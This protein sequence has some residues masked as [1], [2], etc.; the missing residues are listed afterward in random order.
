MIR[1]SVGQGTEPGFTKAGESTDQFWN[2]DLDDLLSILG[3]NSCGKTHPDCDVIT[4]DESEQRSPRASKYDIGDA[5]SFFESPQSF[6]TSSCQN[7]IHAVYVGKM[8]STPN[9][10]LRAHSQSNNCL[11]LLE[12]QLL[13]TNQAVSVGARA[14]PMINDVVNNNI[15][16]IRS[17]SAHTTSYKTKNSSPA[18]RKLMGSTQCSSRLFGILSLILQA[19][20]SPMTAELEQSCVSVMQRALEEIQNAH[21]YFQK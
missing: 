3:L 18:K 1:R 6:Q 10:G 5:T 14:V 9:S 13:E 15:Q 20:D 16:P 4:I 2:Q 11:V 19:F 12:N 8:H 17:P 21:C 7:E